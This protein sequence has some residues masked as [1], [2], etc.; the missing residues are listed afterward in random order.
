VIFRRL[1]S[2]AGPAA[3][4]Y[5]IATW[6]V[7]GFLRDVYDPVDDAISRLAEQGAPNR[8]IV[9]SGMVVFGVGALSF[10]PLLKRPARLALSV[11]GLASL[12]VAVFPCSEGCP[13]DGATIDLV[14]A[15]FAALFYISFTATPVLQSRTRYAIAISTVAAISLSLHGLSIANG[16]MQRIGVTALDLWLIYTGVSGRGLLHGDNV[17]SR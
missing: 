10:A 14:H 17:R 2:T 9:T 8:W 16:L 3:A 12:G 5:F 4:A 1:R 11:A 6:V 7:A 13:R 15:G